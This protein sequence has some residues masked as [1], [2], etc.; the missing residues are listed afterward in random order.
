ME[1]K[2]IRNKQREFALSLFKG[3]IDHLDQIDDAIKKHLQNWDFERV[4][5]IDRAILRLGA[6]EL[7]FSD[8]DKAITINE[9]VELA[10][11]LGANESPKFINGV[12]DAIAKEKSGSQKT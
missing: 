10:K 12:L 3:T 5:S 7:L 6:Y 9:A 1:E 11:K 8:L 4:S 2:K